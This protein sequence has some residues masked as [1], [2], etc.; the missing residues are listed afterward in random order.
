VCFKWTELCGQIIP[1]LWGRTRDICKFNFNSICS[2]WGIT[3]FRPSAQHRT[4]PLYR[5]VTATARLYKR[6]S[7]A[8]RLT[9]RIQLHPLQS[10]ILTPSFGSLQHDVIS[11]RD[12]RSSLPLPSKSWKS[13]LKRV[14]SDPSTSLSIHRYLRI[15][16]SK[17]FERH[18]T[19]Q[20]AR[21]DKPE[22]CI[23]VCMYIYIYMY[24][25]THPSATSIA[26]NTF[27]IIQ[28]TYTWRLFSSEKLP[29]FWNYI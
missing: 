21:S 5:T 10:A 16:Y 22:K 12:S 11:L 20:K 27:H 23:H 3:A 25:H 24:K 19:I 4:R 26:P 15:A 2:L 1:T 17:P 7:V 14:I 9:V 29:T 8:I 13:S 28:L 6:Y 18:W